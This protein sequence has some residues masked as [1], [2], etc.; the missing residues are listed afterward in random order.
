MPPIADLK[1]TWRILVAVALHRVTNLYDFSDMTIRVVVF[2]ILGEVL[3]ATER[4]I[5]FCQDILPILTR[6]GCNAGTCHGSP[7]GKGGFA[8]SLMAFDAPKDYVMLTRDMHGRRIDMFDPELSLILRKPSNS[9]SHRGG[10]K[11][12]NDGRE[13]Q[14]LRKW[15]AA[16]CVDDTATQPKCNSI[17][18]TPNGAAVLTFPSNTQS[19]RVKAEFSDGSSREVTH[20]VKF[21]SS[22]ESIASVSHNGLVKGL[23]RGQVAISARY[24][25]HVVSR[26]F[27]F[28]QPVASFKWNNPPEA[29]Y[30]DKHVHTKLRQMQFLPSDLCSDNE[31]VRRVHLDVIGRL[32]TIIEVE[33]FL[34]DKHDDKRAQLINILL[35]RPEY[36]TFWA[37]KWGD[38]L[39]LHPGTVSASGTHKFNRWL[40]GTFQNNMR[41]D[42][43]AYKLLT[44][45]GSTFSHPQANYYR[46]AAN[47][48]DALETTAQIFLGS[49]LACAKCHNHPFERWTQDNY[50]GLGAVFNRVQ[51]K[52]GTRPDEIFILMGRSGEVTQPRTG[53]TMKPWIPGR[54][55][56]DVPANIDRRRVFADWLTN[57]DNVWFAKVEAN[58]LWASVMGQGIVEPIDDFRDSNPPVNPALLDALAADFAKNG[59]DRKILLRVILNSRTYQASARPT[60]HNAEDKILFS[61]YQP[62]L[63]TAEQLLD[64][65]VQVT[66]V[67]ETFPNLPTGTSATALPSPQLNN[68]FLKIFGQPARSSACACE[69]PQEPQLGQAL[70]LLN[71]KF[72]HGR[73]DSK[74]NRIS[75]LLKAKKSNSE[76]ITEL[77]LLALS[78]RPSLNEMK[79]AKTHI[80]NSEN[81]QKALS[82]ICW[83]VLN[84]N[85]FL[86]QH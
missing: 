51:R 38:L 76:I 44:A 40:V 4:P 37:Q 83:S 46:T 8:L 82:D 25:E 31:F 29:N 62:H 11:L 36:A 12:P 18:V 55:Y 39:R 71:G 70:E 69:R 43:F 64:A 22:D 7:S 48:S 33:T 13:Y 65:V 53:Q 84:L 75:L 45:S 74:T 17:Q 24:L 68:T 52:P 58:R 9:L 30:I 34:N 56:I 54:G 1:H 73:L 28:V 41:Y 27:T 35:E 2:L 81:R 19:M 80:A 78:R 50:Y 14:I 10:L 6:Q 60:K 77:Y 32:P 59:F 42:Q 47:M 15:I 63:L 72:L 57:T 23:K 20:L 49:R 3:L 26:H 86:F 67:S 61:H 85:E 21:T 79:L 66:G 16:G 5:S